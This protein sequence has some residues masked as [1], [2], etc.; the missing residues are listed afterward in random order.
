MNYRGYHFIIGD[1]ELPYAPSELTITIG[2]KNETVELINGNEINILKNPK[3]TEYKFEVE[4]P[5]GRQYPFAN[6]LVSSKTYTDYFEKLM[7]AKKPVR[8]VI[9]RP[10][11]MIAGQNFSSETKVIVG[12]T[13]QDFDS[14]DKL[15]T[16]EGYEMKESAENAFDVTVSLTLKEYIEYGTIKK[17]IV[18]QS[19]NGSSKSSIPETTKK[20]DDSKKYKIVKGDTLWGISKKFYGSGAKWK[21]IYDANKNVIEDTAKK[22]GKKSSSNGHWIYPGCEIVIPAS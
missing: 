20:N 4:L 3:L 19:S 15:V 22:Y 18:K 13:K 6:A 5:R 14:I 16:L 7:V 10:N 9:S 2:S 21:T 11:P 12:G 8:F 1:L 17:V